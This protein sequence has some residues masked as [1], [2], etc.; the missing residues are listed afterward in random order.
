MLPLSMVPDCRISIHT[1]AKGVTFVLYF[2]V[3]HCINFNP[4][5]REGS[6]FYKCGSDLAKA[7]SI[8]TP[9]K[10]VTA[11]AFLMLRLLLISIHTPAKGVTL[12]ICSDTLA[13][14]YFNP[15][16]REGSDCLCTVFNIGKI[17]FNP[18]S[19]EGSDNSFSLVMDFNTFQSTL[20]RRE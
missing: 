16:S 9:A 10:G 20:P 19:R 18:H 12:L 17:H 2:F 8:H 5:S 6:D 11:T 3:P 7:I 14:R 4:H 15:H 1:P 13:C